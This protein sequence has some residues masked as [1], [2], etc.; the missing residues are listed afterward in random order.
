M[1]VRVLRE[2]TRAYRIGDP[3]GRFSVWSTE[4]AQ[5]LAARWHDVGEEVIYA[6]E[7]YSTALLEKLVYSNGVLPPNQHFVEVSIPAGVSYEVVTKDSL[8]DWSHPSCASARAF[9]SK[10]Y[11]ESRSAILFVPS[12]VARMERNIIINTRHPDWMP[13]RIDVG[14]EEPVYWDQRL[15]LES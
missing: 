6:S 8:P 5:Q 4:G 7:H 2:V 12:V 14:L 15:F 9:G 11:R 10:W 3:N 13:N 1:T